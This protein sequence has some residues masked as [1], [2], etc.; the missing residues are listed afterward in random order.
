MNNDLIQQF[1]EQIAFERKEL[2]KDLMGLPLH[3]FNRVGDFGCGWGFI[4]WC[5]M[6]EIT[7]AECVGLD[8]FDPKNPPYLS[9][10][11]NHAH[12]SRHSVE[13]QLRKISKDIRSRNSEHKEDDL[14]SE[15]RHKIIDK[16]RFPIFHKADLVSA[17][18]LSPYLNSYFHL[19]YCKR[20]LFNISIDSKENLVKAIT[21]IAN[22]LKPQGWFCFVELGIPNYLESSLREVGFELDTP[23]EVVRRYERWDEKLATITTEPSPYWIYHCQKTE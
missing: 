14:L 17:K 6:L 20:F 10:I 3:A 15:I 2:Q 16:E 23:R 18:G 11:L 5:L 9:D 19:I 1:L 4:T 22:A 13:T 7:K 8:K 21:H 12:F